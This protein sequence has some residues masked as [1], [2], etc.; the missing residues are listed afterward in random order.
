LKTN[1]NSD[2]NPHPPVDFEERTPGFKKFELI[3]GHNPS[4]L[5]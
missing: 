3:I 5:A 1:I 2:E 4:D